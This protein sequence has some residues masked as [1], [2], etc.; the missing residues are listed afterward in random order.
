MP[1]KFPETNRSAFK[2]PVT[3]KLI[4]ERPTKE[5]F[6]DHQVCQITLRCAAKG[7]KKMLDVCSRIREFR[8]SGQIQNGNVWFE[9]QNV[10]GEEYTSALYPRRYWKRVAHAHVSSILSY[11]FCSV[12]IYL[13][14]IFP[15][16]SITDSE[17]R[18]KLI[19]LPYHPVRHWKI[20]TTFDGSVG[21]DT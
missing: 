20:L 5:P 4:C 11:S 13:L 14:T 7:R 3:A 10:R 1:S 6:F 12:W 16:V 8:T 21:T 17:S 19:A 15:A 9:S 18:W 2:T